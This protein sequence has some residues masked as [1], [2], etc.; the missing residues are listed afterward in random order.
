MKK[1]ND[2]FFE[3][4][5]EIAEAHAVFV[6]QAKEIVTTQAVS[7]PANQVYLLDKPLSRLVTRLEQLQ[8]LAAE[9]T[10]YSLGRLSWLDRALD[11]FRA[12]LAK[13][14]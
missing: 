8:F 2:P 14:V 3:R 12:E 6:N 13:M 7:D 10:Q 11:E 9:G 5:S 1:T 4:I